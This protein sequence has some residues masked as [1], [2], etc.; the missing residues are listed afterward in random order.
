MDPHH[1]PW[2]LIL[3]AAFK[4]LAKL[5]IIP[6]TFVAF[7]LRRLYQRRRQDRAFAAW[8]ATEARLLYGKVH[9]EGPR[10]YW[11]ELTY[12]YYVDEYRSG[13]HVHR[14]RKEEDADEFVRKVKDKR[15]QVRYN[16]AKP[17]ESVIL[18]RDLEMV[19]LLTPLPG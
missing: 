1:L 17:D 8:P 16:P 13:K 2:R 11:V 5:G 14:F 18:D 3:L 10:Q 4:L 6:G 12:S 19:A 9:S 15:L 7:G